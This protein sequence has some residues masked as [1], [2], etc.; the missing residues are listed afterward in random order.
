MSFGATFD[1]EAG[2]TVEDA[3]VDGTDPLAQR[4][5]EHALPGVGNAFDQALSANAT[6][7]T[8]LVADDMDLLRA[9]IAA[10][11][12]GTYA[13]IQRV[14][15]DPEVGLAEEQIEYLLKVAEELEPHKFRKLFRLGP[16]YHERDPRLDALAR[17]RAASVLRETAPGLNGSIVTSA[18]EAIRDAAS[19]AL[20][21]ASQRLADLSHRV[22]R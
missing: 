5:H 1:H 13:H 8:K 16:R 6:I 3:D 4:L 11:A 17:Q 7:V 22:S 9:L 14:L 21:T 20:R 12:D 18:T 19:R 15:A 10:K 2:T